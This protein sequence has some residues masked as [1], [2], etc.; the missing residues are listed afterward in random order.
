MREKKCAI[1]VAAEAPK[2]DPAV[3]GMSTKC[4]VLSQ[5]KSVDLGAGAQDT[6]GQLQERPHGTVTARRE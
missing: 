2:T 6:T 5:N 4:A 3:R 1:F